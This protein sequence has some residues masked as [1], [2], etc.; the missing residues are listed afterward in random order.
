LNASV[1]KSA[2]KRGR[3]QR[4]TDTALEFIQVPG[5][6]ALARHRLRPD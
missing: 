1:F 4:L 3:A 5:T 2:S 6:A